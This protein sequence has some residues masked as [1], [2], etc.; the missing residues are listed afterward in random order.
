MRRITDFI[1]LTRY[2]ERFPQHKPPVDEQA[3]EIKFYSEQKIFDKKVSLN[4]NVQTSKLYLFFVKNSAYYF[5]D[6]LPFRLKLTKYKNIEII[7]SYEPSFFIFL[8][9][10]FH[11]IILLTQII[12]FF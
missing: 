11:F 3:R 9:N 1:C 6:L 5:K 12:T 10:I 4:H 7:K 8:S 2:R